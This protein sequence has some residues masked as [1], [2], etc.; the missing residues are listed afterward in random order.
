[1]P[2]TRQK[3]NRRYSRRSSGKSVFDGKPTLILNRYWVPKQ[4]IDPVSDVI[5]AL[6][7]DVP[8]NKAVDQVYALHSNSI[9]RN[10]LAEH[11]LKYI[12]NQY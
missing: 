5:N 7:H 10:K 8:F 6:K 9:N 12:A 1:M 4:Y 2:N 3:Q 11:T